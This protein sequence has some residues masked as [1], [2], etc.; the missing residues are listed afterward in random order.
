M[1]NCGEHDWEVTCAYKRAAGLMAEAARNLPRAA[2]EERVKALIDADGYGVR[3][4][5]ASVVP[6][7]HKQC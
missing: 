4:E 6:V 1:E 3:A 7:E 2:I 5:L